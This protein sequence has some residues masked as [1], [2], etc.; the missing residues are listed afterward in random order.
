MSLQDLGGGEFSAQEEWLPKDDPKR[1]AWEKERE[2]YNKRKCFE[3]AQTSVNLLPSEQREKISDGYH[4]FKE[5]YDH[6]IQIYIALC[7]E[8]TKT[9]KFK[10]WRTRFHSDGTSFEGWFVLGIGYDKGEQI[11]YHLP[12]EKWH[13]CAFAVDLSE[14]PTFDGHTSADVLERLKQL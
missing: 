5:L 7:R 11:T 1:I 12:L 13:E 4:T 6:R 2:I 8:I 10:V 14:A 3:N 9:D